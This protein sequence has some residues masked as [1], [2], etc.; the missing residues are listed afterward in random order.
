M[1]KN[2]KQHKGYWEARA[3]AQGER[4]VGYAGLTEEE[5]ARR[6]DQW[7]NRFRKYWESHLVDIALDFG[8]GV[9]RFTRKLSNDVIG[10]D[11]TKK[12]IDIAQ[13]KDPDSRY[14]HMDDP[15]KIPLDNEMVDSIWCCTVLQ[16]L[17]FPGHAQKII[18]EFYRVLNPKGVVLFFENTAF[19]DRHM[20]H[21]HFRS[22]AQYC[23]HFSR[24]GF[25]SV[26]V[27]R[28]WVEDGNEKHTL[29]LARK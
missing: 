22:D 18:K 24:A 14:I 8:C 26:K 21:I 13:S 5:F 17:V 4:T 29:F 1:I 12:L 25:S 28:S 3:N 27:I 19:N 15:E 20:G 16:H 9:G 10:V 23:E 2:K 11:I 7:V 6:S